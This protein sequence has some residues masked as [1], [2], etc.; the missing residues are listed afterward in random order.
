M[1][2]LSKIYISMLTAINDHQAWIIHAEATIEYDGRAY[3]TLQKGTYIIIRKSDGSLMIHGATLCKALN[4]QPPGATIQVDNDEITSQYKKETIRIKFYNIINIY[5]IT[6]WS[7]YKIKISKTEKDAKKIIIEILPNIIPNIKQIYDEFKTTNGPID[8]VA[9]DDQNTHHVIE[10]KRKKLYLN[11][12]IQL[13]KY[14]DYFK[15]SN[16]TAK[17]YLAGT[18]ISDK[19]NNRL[20]DVR[21]IPFRF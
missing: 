14:L 13:N 18:S 6:I 10:I 5:P 16:I 12:L 3:S 15:E 1:L 7:D 20:G 17:G 21:F 8:L 11:H 19:L 4:Y 9:I 2:T